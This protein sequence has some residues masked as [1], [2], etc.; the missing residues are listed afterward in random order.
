MYPIRCAHAMLRQN[1]ATKSGAWRNASLM[2]LHVHAMSDARS[3][4]RPKGPHPCKPPAPLHSRTL[5][6]PH[7]YEPAPSKPFRLKHVG[8][9]RVR[10]HPCRRP[11]PSSP[12]PCGR[13]SSGPLRVWAYPCR[14]HPSAPAPCGRYA[15]DALWVRA[16][17]CRPRPLAPAPCGRYAPETVTTHYMPARCPLSPRQAGIHAS[18]GHGPEAI[19][20]VVR[21]G[22]CDRGTC[23]MAGSQKGGAVF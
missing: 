19:A 8:S 12:A 1:I 3:R 11:Q 20:T 16:R 10:A 6:N 15:S 22:R 2:Q 21:H 18:A 5:T 9:G 7:P 14:P 23:G 4:S 17:P 13:C